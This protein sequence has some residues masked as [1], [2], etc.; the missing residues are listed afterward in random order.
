MSRE[1]QVRIRLSRGRRCRSG[2]PRAADLVEDSDDDAR[3]VL[4]R[5]DLQIEVLFAVEDVLRDR[6]AEADEHDDVGL[7]TKNRVVSAFALENDGSLGVCQDALQVAT[8]GMPSEMSTTTLSGSGV[9]AGLCLD[10]GDEDVVA[11]VEEVIL[12]NSRKPRWLSLSSIYD[13]S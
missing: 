7:L 2:R 8:V 4:R 1:K 12:R 6:G 13:V 11:G 10:R 3:E 9:L 5:Q